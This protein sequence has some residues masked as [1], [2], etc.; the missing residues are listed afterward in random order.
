[1]PRGLLG[2]AT[3]IHCLAQSMVLWSSENMQWGLQIFLEG[4]EGGDQ[5]Q[6]LQIPD[7]SQG[8]S[9]L[10]TQ[11]PTILEQVLILQLVD[12][13][14]N[15]R[16]GMQPF[17]SHLLQLPELTNMLMSSLL[18]TSYSKQ[19]REGF[20]THPILLPLKH[21]M[22]VC[23]SCFHLSKTFLTLLLTFDL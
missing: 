18:P 4:R 19:V 17:H 2:G 7:Y 22:A 8:S 10:W 20:S 23:I 11:S 5:E 6:V 1:M 14:P 9:A 16:S 3:W 13:G 15:R 21:L 12:V